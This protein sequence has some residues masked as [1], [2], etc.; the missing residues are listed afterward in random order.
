MLP[1]SLLPDAGMDNV[2]AGCTGA[3]KLL[4]LAFDMP[5]SPCSARAAQVWD[6]YPGTHKVIEL[7]LQLDYASPGPPA[8]GAINAAALNLHCEA[9]KEATSGR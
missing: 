8:V 2:I 7:R 1:A 4:V 5:C 3:A 9:T 6:T